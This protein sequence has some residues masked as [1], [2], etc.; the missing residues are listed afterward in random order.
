MQFDS[1]LELALY[2]YCKLNDIKCELH[3][4]VDISYR[5]EDKMHSYQP[6]FRIDN[7]LVEVKGLHFFEDKDPA[8]AMI[9]PFDRS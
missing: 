9:N 2:M 5:F 1:K 3:P 8:K 4:E 7:D 6:D